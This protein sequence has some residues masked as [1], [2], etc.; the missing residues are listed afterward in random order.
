M[1]ELRQRGVALVARDD[2][3]VIFAPKGRVTPDIRE[4]LVAQKPEIL[5]HLRNAMV[6]KAALTRKACLAEYASDR[7]PAIRLTL[8]ETEDMLS[9]FKVL[10]AIRD[11]IGEY[12]PG[13]NHIF[14]K[15]VTL[16]GRRVTLEW[17]ALVEPEL[18]RR[19]AD[20][21]AAHATHRRSASA[22]TSA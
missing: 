19:L 12:Q 9:D 5:R 4:S 6:E 17:R 13:G 20:I 14:M 10:D 1:E 15:V 11:A 18:R 2:E 8:R 7:L 3:L 21:L 22:A 16:E